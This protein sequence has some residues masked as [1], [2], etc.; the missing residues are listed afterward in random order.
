MVSTRGIKT[1]QENKP[2]P[3]ERKLSS[4]PKSLLSE[5]IT[6]LNKYDFNVVPAIG[7]IPVISWLEYQ[8]RKI[9]VKELK[10]IWTREDYNIALITGEISNNTVVVDADSETAIKELKKRGLPRTP[11][12]K[13]K[14]GF[15]Y[16]FKSETPVKSGKISI[17]GV[18]IKAQ[19]S[20]VILPPSIHPEG[21]QYMWVKGLSPDAVAFSKLPEWISQEVGTHNETTAHNN[22]VSIFN[23]VPEGRRNCSL[24]KLVGMWFKI[25]FDFDEV[26]NLA[27]TWNSLNQPPLAEK[28]VINTVKSIYRREIESRKKISLITTDIVNS[29]K[30]IPEML[31]LI[32]KISQDEIIAKRITISD[33]AYALE[34]TLSNKQIT[35]KEE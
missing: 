2:Q 20:I 4:K 6:Y 30:D 1:V 25:G 23:G 3:S 27:F 17:P 11:V 22:L 9:T 32:A 24:T 18:D 21:G 31:N 14:R 13:T 28:E 26:L 19:G 10:S 29:I 16:Y 12:V 5:A 15:H 7:K 35:N 33:I 34:K 8:K